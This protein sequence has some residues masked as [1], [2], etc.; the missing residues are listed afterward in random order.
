LAHPDSLFVYNISTGILYHLD[1]SAKVKNKFNL[2]DFSDFRLPVP[3]PSTTTPAYRVGRKIIFPCGLNDYQSVLKDYPSVLELDLTT[4]NIKYLTTFSSYCGE[5]FWGSFFKYEPSFAVNPRTQQLVLNYPVDP[6]LYSYEQYGNG[7]AIQWY[8]GSEEFGAVHPYSAD[9]LFFQKRNNREIDE[10]ENE[11]AFSTSEYRSIIYDP[12]RDLYYRMALIRPS[13][14]AGRNGDL[15]PDFSII[16]LDS[17]FKKLGEQFFSKERYDPSSVFFSS[18]GINI[19][20]RDL[21][22]KNE[23]KAFFEVFIPDEVL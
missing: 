4:K 16:I 9:P 2:T 13:I 3:Y 10:R 17:N 23:E 11:Y 19:F 12:F 18:V 14:E 1:S 15:K 21:Y 5:A 8:V 20:R 7:S 6:W 22:Q